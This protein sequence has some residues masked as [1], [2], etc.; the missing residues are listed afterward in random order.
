M[1]KDVSARYVTLAA[2]DEFVLPTA[3]G[4]LALTAGISWDMQDVNTFKTLSEDPATLNQLK[5]RYIMGDD[6]TIY[7]SRD[8]FNPVAGL[9]FDPIEDVLRFRMSASAKTEFPSLKVYSSV[10][11][12]DID[13]QVK[14]ERSFNGNAGAEVWLL[15]KRVNVRADYFYSDFRDKIERIYDRDLGK[16][17]YSNIDGRVVQGAES[18]VALFFTPVEFM[19]VNCELTNVYIHAENKDDSS[20]PT[21]KESRILP[22]QQF[23]ARLLLRFTTVTALMSG[24]SI[25]PVKTL[26][27]EHQS[28]YSGCSVFASRVH[29]GKNCTIH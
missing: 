19:I 26:C 16:Y 13:K 7:G 24:G 14:P 3:I 23:M 20:K 2:E 6:S 11:A 10:D 28:G 8:A 22:E 4:R 27:D 21:A 17:I 5:D 15:S 9:V 12:A 1:V 18:T 29:H 25:Q